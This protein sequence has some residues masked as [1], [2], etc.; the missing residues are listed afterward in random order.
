LPF[1]RAVALNLRG[2]P[3]RAGCAP[4]PAIPRRPGRRVVADG[5]FSA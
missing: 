4:V 3:T 2:P 5:G 1:Q